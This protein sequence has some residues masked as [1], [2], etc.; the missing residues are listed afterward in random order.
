M[1]KTKSLLI[2]IS[3]LLFSNYYFSSFPQELTITTYYPSPVGIYKELRAKKMAIGDNYYNPSSYSWGFE[4]PSDADL[5]VE[6]K[7]GI[8]TT[9]P[10]EEL[11][12]AGDAKIENNLNVEGDAQLGDSGS[13]K[14]TVKGDLN[15]SGGIVV[16]SPTGGNKGTGTINA[17]KI[18]VNGSEIEGGECVIV[19]KG[20]YC[21]CAPCPHAP[22]SCTAAVSVSCPEGMTIKSACT[23]E[24]STYCASCQEY[25]A[26]SAAMV[27][28]EDDPAHPC[29]GNTS[30]SIS[31]TVTCD[32]VAVYSR[33]LCCK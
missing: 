9:D 22:A 21:N 2:L 8:G 14:T 3:T 17:E 11:H 4:I 16:G 32:N 7:V 13:D 29:V 20:D 31:K 28:C 27:S 6:G 5:V 18:Y 1:R 33:I 26:K 24:V 23:S 30:C 19:S 12:V 10:E 25:I 15:V